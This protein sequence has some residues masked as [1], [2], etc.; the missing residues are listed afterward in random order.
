MTEEAPPKLFEHCSVVYET[1][2]KAAKGTTVEGTYALVYEGYLTRLF[3]DRQLAMPYYT[4]VMR[5]LK[6]MGCVRQLSRGGGSSPS[7][8]ELLNEPSFED[9]DIIETVRREN[10]TQLGQVKGTVKVLSN[11]LREVEEKLDAHLRSTGEMD[12]AV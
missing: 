11:R 10:D 12:Q 7:R 5:R 6:A 9:F 8:W 1:M 4:A 3:A 2:R